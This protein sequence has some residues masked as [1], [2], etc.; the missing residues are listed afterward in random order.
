[1]TKVKFYKDKDGDIFAY[2]P[3]IP[4]TN[5]PGV[6]TC[7]SHVGQHSACRESYAMECEEALF[8]SPE[9][10]YCEL[11]R[12]LISIGYNDL[13]IMNTQHFECWRK[14]TK[15]EKEQGIKSVAWLN[16]TAKEVINAKTGHIKKWFKAS[17]GLVYYP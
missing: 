7:Y 6:F 1:M 11:L 5:E 15:Q 2:F 12:E 8:S 17:N 10:G 14:P 4:G 16:F 9:N 3:E 13:Q